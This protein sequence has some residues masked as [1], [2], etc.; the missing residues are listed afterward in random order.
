MERF[1]A[2]ALIVTY[3]AQASIGL[4]L[5]VAASLATWL[6]PLIGWIAG[7]GLALTAAAL[8]LL[9]AKSFVELVTIVTEMLVPR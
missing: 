4:S 5:A 6:V 7:A 9:L 8:T 2:L 3:G 1:P